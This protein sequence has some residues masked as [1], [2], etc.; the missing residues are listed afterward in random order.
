[1]PFSSSTPTYDVINKT[2]AGSASS[3][4]SPVSR[5]RSHSQSGS[6][7]APSRSQTRSDSPNNNNTSG[8][9]TTRSNS[10]PNSFSSNG[11]NSSL[12]VGIN[13]PADK[14]NIA[15]PYTDRALVNSALSSDYNMI[16]SRIS[17]PAY[18]RR[19]EELYSKSEEAWGL[20]IATS[21]DS[22]SNQRNS[23]Q[24]GPYSHQRVSSSAHSVASRT[25]S[26]ASW[27][28]IRSV[29]G[30]S[31]ASRR[32]RVWPNAVRSQDLHPFDSLSVPPLELDDILLLPGPH[33]QKVIALA[34]PWAELD[35][36]N[37]SVAALS[38]QALIQEVMYAVY[39]GVVYIVLPGPKRRTNV[40]QYASAVA[41][42]LATAP[43][44]VQLMV[45]LPFAE[46]DYV[47]SRTGIHVP[48]AD[49]L[50]IWDVWNTIRTITNYP[51][52]LS[53]ALQIPPKCSGLPPAVANRWYAEPVK[54]L[55]LSAS[56]FMPNA[57][58]Y[59][60]LPKATQNLLFRFFS[61]SPFIMLA[62]VYDFHDFAGGH[63][64]YLLYLRH[65]LRIRPKP[66]LIDSY[67]AP[68]ADML[69]LPLQ[70]LADNL[71]NAT[72]EVFER[73]ATKYN[74][75]E[76]AIAAALMD[77]PYSHIEVA[78]AGAGRGPLVEKAL[79]AAA[80]VGKTVHIYAIEK[81]ASACI[82]LTR[83]REF[84]WTPE[85]LASSPNNIS[86]VDVVHSD[87]RSWR[88]PAG[89][90]SRVQLIVSEL[91]G[92]F[93]DNELSPECIDALDNPEV[94]DPK[95]G[96]II[97]QEY[98]AWFTP[99]MSPELYKAAS[100]FQFPNSS[101]STF[102][103]STTDAAVNSSAGS[104]N[105]GFKTGPNANPLNTSSV[106]HAPYVVH[107]N[108]I[109]YIAP[110]QYAKAWTFSHP[111]PT[112]A[113][114]AFAETSSEANSSTN[115]VD[116]D[117]AT[118]SPA[119]GRGTSLYQEVHR[120]NS[121]VS[122]SSGASAFR[123]SSLIGSNVN[124]NSGFNVSAPGDSDSHSLSFVSS[125]PRATA[126]NVSSTPGLSPAA[127][128]ALAETNAA[129][130]TLLSAASKNLTNTRK[131]KHTFQIPNQC[132]IHGLAGFFEC[133]LYGN[134]GFSTRP[135]L[136]EDPTTPTSSTT[137]VNGGRSDT[138]LSYVPDSGELSES[139][140]GT[141][142]T[143]KN[144]TN[145]VTAPSSRGTAFGIP[146]TKDM[147]SWFPIWFPFSR[148]MYINE[149]SEVDISMWRRT[150]GSRVWYE[151]AMESF[152]STGKLASQKLSPDILEDLAKASAMPPNFNGNGMNNNMSSIEYDVDMSEEGHRRR[153]KQVA[154]KYAELQSKRRIRTGSSELHNPGGVHY[155]MLL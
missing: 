64:S 18:R 121:R 106:F 55:T 77:I 93:G 78:I 87:L 110:S 138:P 20:A 21:R 115:G 146:Q 130:K 153:I 66:G 85:N 101:S 104:Y 52:N 148:P 38:V 122:S 92:S 81:N 97:P 27:H 41:Q 108:S 102:P 80:T 4:L 145:N 99:V 15:H 48:P 83:R 86:S 113:Y 47:S 54:M 136:A 118:Y 105:A 43:P 29:S 129:V 44:R 120:N 127:A 95:H 79:N 68:Y 103:N 107:F 140:F 58:K 6:H 154:D 74:I 82:H 71:E 96:I 84:E 9:N 1:M 109:D 62:D 100:N 2:S 14:P 32:T 7:R 111:S 147:L 152:L 116:N 88:P 75:Y 98:A 30:A 155:S 22:N 144:S 11:Y 33:L 124:A 10:F 57:K 49:H 36:K 91:L 40:E 65:L 90:S 17:S 137:S 56:I 25:S 72:Y 3:L 31:N 112:G 35:S 59:P 23:Y 133:R 128:T 67:A 28:H 89:P 5:R 13:L 131:I 73:D 39:C 45:N 53:V 26:A 46:D 117:S 119:A 70:P 132:V 149:Q 51:P 34:A 61:K 19:I 143:V 142:K 42:I 60:V 135:D 126:N 37:P 139:D 114:L 134:I 76:K 16:T 151:W 63:Q 141:P 123:P 50:S 8:N 12:F 24:Q 150:D 69:Q 94:L 125:S